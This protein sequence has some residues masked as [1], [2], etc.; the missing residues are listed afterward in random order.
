MK[1]LVVHARLHNRRAAEIEGAGTWQA[2]EREGGPVGASHEG[3]AHSQYPAL[4]QTSI[5]LLYKAA[6]L[7]KGPT[8]QKGK[9]SASIQVEL[10]HRTAQHVAVAAHCQFKSSDAEKSPEKE[11][12]STN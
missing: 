2:K 3:E 12:I 11:N 7:L 5:R 6:V 9:R 8:K 10:R 4:L 1:C